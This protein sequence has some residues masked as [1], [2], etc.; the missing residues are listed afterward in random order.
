MATG[1]SLNDSRRV[2][3]SAAL[4]LGPLR[5]SVSTGSKPNPSPPIAPGVS[6]T[7]IPRSG[8]N[9]EKPP[10]PRPPWPS[11]PAPPR[12][13][14]AAGGR[15]PGEADQRVARGG[16]AGVIEST[17]GGLPP[18]RRPG[19]RTP[20][21]VAAG[22]AGGGGIITKSVRSPNSGPPPVPGA[23]PHPL[24]AA[25]HRIAE[26]LLNVVFATVSW[27]PRALYTPPPS[28]APLGRLDRPRPPVASLPDVEPRTGPFP[29]SP[30][31]PH[32]PRRRRSPHRR[33]RSWQRWSC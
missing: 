8:S 13:P 7:K 22:T 31:S 5:A 29:R 23:Q 9:S 24:A 6:C 32:R 21:P 3:H 26:L 11:P 20:D 27:A 2:V 1:R 17:S 15:V 14:G 18:S 10:P 19:P 28:P 25:A 12:P 4:R 30:E 33:S 16:R